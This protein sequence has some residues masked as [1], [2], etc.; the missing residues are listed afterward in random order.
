MHGKIMQTLRTQVYI[1]NA[2]QAD[3]TQ[4]SQPP[5]SRSWDGGDVLCLNS[6]SPGTI[7]KQEPVRY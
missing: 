6:G 7:L 1:L 3:P 4:A 2:Q 5:L